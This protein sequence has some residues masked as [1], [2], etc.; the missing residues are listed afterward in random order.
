[1][2]ASL[3]Q[4]L[5]TITVLVGVSLG[6]LFPNFGM[7]WKP[8]VIYLLMLLIFSSAL[9]IEPDK[10]IRSAYDVKSLAYILLTIFVLSPILALIGKLFFSPMTFAGIV[11]A[12][13][14]PSA[15]SV[16]FY[17][18]IFKGDTAYGLLISIITNLLAI[19]TIPITMFLVL[20]T[21]INLDLPSVFLNLAEV[22]LVP[23]VLAFLIQRTLR[24]SVMRISR[25]TSRTNLVLS[26][27]IIWGSMA[28]GVTYAETNPMQFLLVVVFI[29][30]LLVALFTV[31]YKLSVAKGSIDRHKKAITTAIAV[32]ARNGSLPLVIASALFNSEILLPLMANIVAQC[33]FLAALGTLIGRIHNIHDCK[34]D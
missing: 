17:T 30:T 32:S 24:T 2:N 21:T 15:L 13:S 4:N 12:L 9:T 23:M 25:F 26:I 33:L 6:F 20:R 28:A 16:A 34:E 14:A 22:I 18:G 1:M 5:V 19:L 7:E 29:V 11:L 8:H 31:T 27:P 10:V 3:N